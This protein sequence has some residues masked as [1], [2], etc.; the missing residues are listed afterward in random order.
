M[1]RALNDTYKDCM[2]SINKDT[3]HDHLVYVLKVLHNIQD[4]NKTLM[5]TVNP[6]QANYVY[7]YEECRTREVNI[8]QLINLIIDSMSGKVRTVTS[9]KNIPSYESI[10]FTYRKRLA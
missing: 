3:Q 5:L 2:G 10:N 7:S 9:E 1:S 8:D 4:M 6:R